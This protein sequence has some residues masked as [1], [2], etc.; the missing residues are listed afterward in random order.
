MP[1]P[2]SPAT[3]AGL[4]ASRLR[5]ALQ[6]RTVR[7]AA[8]GF[9]VLVPVLAFAGAAGARH[10]SGLHGLVMQGPTRPV[11]HVGDPCE[12]PASGVLLQF[13]R[14]GKV[15][16]EVKTT[17]AGRYSVKLRAGSYSVKAPRRRVGTG[18]T[19]KVVRVPR[20]RI[21]KVDFHLDTGIQ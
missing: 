8:V 17:N 12:K 10:A 18:L 4:Y 14:G 6:F 16:A 15:V 3:S 1:P 5:R 20:G 19:P 9:A 7:W 21:A 13:R 11:C 2:E